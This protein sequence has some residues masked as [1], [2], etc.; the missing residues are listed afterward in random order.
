M[1]PQRK[2]VRRKLR[3]IGTGGSPVT[4]T[5]PDDVFTAEYIDELECGHEQSFANI[6][7]VWIDQP[8]T[9]AC[10]QC[11]TYEKVLDEVIFEYEMETTVTPL[12]E[13]RN[14]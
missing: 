3:R 8:K 4:T 5:L 9:R 6:T 10:R 11:S 1:T 12:A 13:R 14:K 7:V 2:I